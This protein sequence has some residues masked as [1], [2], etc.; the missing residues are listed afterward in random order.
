MHGV[1]E[2]EV[3][4]ILSVILSKLG[5]VMSLHRRLVNTRPQEGLQLEVLEE[6]GDGLFLRYTYG[7]LLGFA[8]VAVHPTAVIVSSLPYVL[9]GPHHLA[10][11]IATRG[12][13]VVSSLVTYMGAP[14]GYASVHV[15]L[16]VGD[17]EYDVERARETMLAF[18]DEYFTGADPGLAPE[19]VDPLPLDSRLYTVRAEPGRLYLYTVGPSHA[20]LDWAGLEPVGVYR[21]SRMGGGLDRPTGLDAIADAVAGLVRR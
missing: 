15:F 12:Y 8:S 19:L 1:A 3:A 17:T 16:A 6:D 10:H 21:V 11:A 14:S 2:A 18:L 7:T 9:P 20:R 4:D 5:A 13:P